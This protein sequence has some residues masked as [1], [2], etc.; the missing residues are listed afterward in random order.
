[1]K[2]Y[3]RKRTVV[4]RKVNSNNRIKVRRRKRK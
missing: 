2:M 4:K 3:Q 1:M